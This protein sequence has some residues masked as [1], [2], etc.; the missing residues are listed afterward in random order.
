MT[1]TSTDIERRA[2]DAPSGETALAVLQNLPARIENATASA[3]VQEHGR[4]FRA[5][6]R[7]VQLFFEDLK[8]D[9]HALHQKMCAKE[10][11]VLEVPTQGLAA[12]KMLLDDYDARLR[13][14]REEAERI[15]REE[16]ER[17]EREA[18]EEAERL[19][20]LAREERERIESARAVKA[21]TVQDERDRLAAIADAEAKAKDLERAAERAREAPRT[22]ASFIAPVEQVV[23]VEGV[24]KSESWDYE[25]IDPTKI[26]VKV[27]RDAMRVAALEKIKASWLGQ[28]LRKIVWAQGEAAGEIIGEGALKIQTKTTRS[29]R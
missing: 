4:T 19:E 22:E 2:E 27:I 1:T 20:A 21:K 9:A 17:V 25:I 26:K 11:I 18:R 6:T 7:E 5:L 8:A 10:R 28:H 29:F 23:A 3:E 24:S 15:A 13:Q 12:V 14:E 16:R